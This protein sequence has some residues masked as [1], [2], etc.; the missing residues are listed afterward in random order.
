[1]QPHR[2]GMVGL[3]TLLACSGSAGD[4]SG[5]GPL[6][7]APPANATAVD[8]SDNV[9][10][11]EAITA[12][13]GATITWTWRGNNPHNVTF[14][15][16]VESSATKSNG[17]HVRAFAQGGTYRY[18]CTIHSSSFTSGMVGSVVIP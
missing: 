2:V 15:D 18:R 7:P 5:T 6:P 13:R 4:G 17:T 8:V 10:A 1:M 9:F 11:P 12:S 3:L 14:E 16:A